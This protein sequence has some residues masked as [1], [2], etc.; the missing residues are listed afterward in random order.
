MPNE[1]I[2]E[3]VA[4]GEPAALGAFDDDQRIWKAEPWRSWGPEVQVNNQLSVGRM[5]YT[6][7]S[8]AKVPSPSIE[9]MA[10]A[11]PRLRFSET[12]WSE[13]DEVEPMQR[14]VCEHG[15]LVERWVPRPASALRARRVGRR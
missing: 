12:T 10:R 4:E 2:S 13:F 11:H 9:E 6:Y 1:Y 14:R 5:I 3:L 15:V 8:N 7:R